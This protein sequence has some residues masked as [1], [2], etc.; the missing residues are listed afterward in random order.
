MTYEQYMEKFD[1]A[2]VKDDIVRWIWYWFQKNGDGCK[3]VIGLSGGK[4][5]AVVAA[6]CVAALGSDRVL[7]VYMPNSRQTAEQ[8]LDNSELISRDYKDVEVLATHLGIQWKLVDIAEPY[9]DLCMNIC[10]ANYVDGSEMNMSTQALIN[11]APRLR[12]ATLYAVS[13]SVGGRVANTCNLSEDW[14][15]YST[16]Y[17]DSVGDFSP[18]SNLT[19][20]EVIAIGLALGLP[21]HLVKKTPSDGVCGKTD[22]DNLGF[23]YR[24]L[25][26]YIRLGTCEDQEV[27]MIID[28]KHQKNLFKLTAM[29][30]FPYNPDII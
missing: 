19:T 27:K 10:A 23:T 13:Q 24:T 3:A 5:S 30:T 4:D 6:L 21:E 14:V 1:A 28:D 7:G 16:R 17:G 29:P 8:R 26:E 25:N 20:D 2:K 9:I 15:G 22:E 11:L 12:M 18:L